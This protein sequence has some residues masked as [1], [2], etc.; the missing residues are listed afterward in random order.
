M[1][2]YRCGSMNMYVLWILYAFFLGSY[3]RTYSRQE[4]QEMGKGLKVRREDH[5]YYIYVGGIK[6]SLSLLAGSIIFFLLIGFINDITYASWIGSILG[7]LSFLLVVLFASLF[8][9][10]S[11]FKYQGDLV[12]DKNERKAGKGSDGKSGSRMLIDPSNPLP[13]MVIPFVSFFLIILAIVTGSLIPIAILF[14]GVPVVISFYALFMARDSEYDGLGGSLETV[15]DV[16][17]LDRDNIPISRIIK[18]FLVL[19]IIIL[20]ILSNITPY[21]GNLDFNP[22]FE[23]LNETE[24]NIED[25]DTFL[26]HYSDV[27]VISWDLATQYLQRAYSDAAS[28]LSTDQDVLTLNTDPD[29]VNGKFVWVNAP[30]YEFLKWTGGKTVPFY[31]YVV[32][33]PENMTKDGF[34]A[35]HRSND[36]FETHRDKISW[37]MRIDQILHNKYA[38]S[39]VNIQIRFTLDEENHPYWVVYLGKRHILYDVVDIEKILIIDASDMDKTWEFDIDDPDIPDWMEVVY[40]DNY[41]LDWAKLWGSWREGITYKWFNKR[42]LSFPDDTPRFLILNG[43]SYWY[44]P[45]RQL[46][47]QVLAGYI[48]MNTRTGETVYHNREALSLADRFTAT[49]QVRQYLSSGIQGFRQLTIQEGYLYPIQMNYGRVREAYIFPLYSGF[50]IQQYAMVDAEFY[51]QNPFFGTDLQTLI[52]EYRSHTFDVDQNITHT[53]TNLTFESA[54]S[55]DE[56]GAFTANGT[57]YIVHR[58]DLAGGAI[59]DAENEWREFRLAVSDFERGEDVSIEVVVYNGEVL[60]VDYP[61]ASLVEH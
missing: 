59:A 17:G 30:Q 1:Y 12:L 37:G 48:L 23:D 9:E 56:E 58:E 29:Y 46:D 5:S 13:F 34:D 14:F 35:V 20:L 52:S 40:P 2:T 31:V 61:E 27:R 8:L 32:N 60:D 39:Y 3:F 15:K 25:A 33:D 7:F 54:Y 57:T 21:T 49:L 42:H 22:T 19:F 38:G 50:T 55:D 26:S 43:T 4:R 16:M 53:W 10:G 6:F 24:N 44:L 47:S 28:T 45:M 36:S 11:Y 51:T 41:L 18:A